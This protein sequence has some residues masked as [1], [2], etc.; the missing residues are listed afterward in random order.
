[1]VANCVGDERDELMEWN[2]QEI[3]I[4]AQD[5]PY[6]EAR[7]YSPIRNGHFNESNYGT[8]VGRPNWKAVDLPKP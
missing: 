5:R 1:M 6:E 7:I 8:I 3:W 2:E 4:Y